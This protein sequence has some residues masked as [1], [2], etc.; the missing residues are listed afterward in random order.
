MFAF[1]VVIEEHLFRH[2]KKSFDRA[3]VSTKQ[4]IR[5]PFGMTDRYTLD[6][7]KLYEEVWTK[8]MTKVSKRYEVS[9]VALAKVCRKLEIPVPERGYWARVAH[10]HKPKR[11]PPQEF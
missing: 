6:R 10:G 9:G 5:L 7:D 4:E 3:S 11:T 2:S 8:P 1:V